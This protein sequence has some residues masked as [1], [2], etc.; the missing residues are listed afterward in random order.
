MSGTAPTA[1]R[2]LA[3]KSME[4]AGKMQVIGGEVLLTS[5]TSFQGGPGCLAANGVE[6][7]RFCLCFGGIVS[8][9]FSTLLERM[10]SFLVPPSCFFLF[11]RNIIGDKEFTTLYPLDAMVIKDV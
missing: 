7:D 5:D 2:A 11:F 3:T 9:M 8:R 6:P 1:R 10:R 4:E